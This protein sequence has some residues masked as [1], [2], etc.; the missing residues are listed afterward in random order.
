MKTKTFSL[1]LVIVCVVVVCSSHAAA[2]NLSLDPF[3]T[4]SADGIIS[5][6]A[7]QS[8]RKILIGGNFSTVSGVTRNKIARLNSDG[9]L[10][11]N[12][13]AG[14]V[15]TT[16]HSVNSIKILAD[17]KI[18]LGGYFGDV[19]LN[20]FK[21][22]VRLNPNGSLDAAF[23]SFPYTVGGG[24]VAAVESLPNGKILMCGD[25]VSA[26]GSNQQ[27]LARYNA[28][29]SL[30]AA[31][32]ATL[33]GNCKDLKSLPDGRILAGGIFSIVNGFS[34]SGLVRLNQD[35]TLDTGFRVNSVNGSTVYIYKTAVQPDGKIVA[36]VTIGTNPKLV[37]LN[38][39]GSPQATFPVVISGIGISTIALQGDG[40]VLIGGS[41]FYDANGN[42]TYFT[43]LNAEGNYDLTQAP[44]AFSDAVN[45]IVVQADGKV[46]VGGNFQTVNGVSRPRIAR[47]LPD[48]VTQKTAFDFDGDRKADIAVFRPSNGTWYFDRSSAG[49]TAT[50]FGISTDK[51]VAADYDG[52]RR[53]DIAVYRNGV[54]YYLRSSD[55]VFVY[56]FFGADGDIP[57]VGDFDGDGKADFAVFR[58]SQRVWM[59]Q[60]STQGLVT[61]QIGSELPTDRP[62]PGD[63]D[64]DGITDIAVY[65]NGLWISK[66]T[67]NNAVVSTAFG[68]A[69]DRPVVGDFDGD[70]KTD[71]AVFRPSDGYWYFQNSTQGFT[72]V[73][74][75]I[76][77][78][79]PVPADYD[80][81]GKTD[82]AV[83]RSG[84]WYQ[85]RSN[86][87]NFYGEQFG[88][89]TDVPIPAQSAF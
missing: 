75:G 10:D 11:A 1:V 15:V 33:N 4:P 71:L 18:L 78:D 64:G 72:A 45:S 89:S 6:V 9:G 77:T 27:Y 7:A 59:I 58:P 49:F 28:D 20:G 12:F 30:D 25:F 44:I 52:D 57:T 63:Y 60:R 43:R 16:A 39:D 8:D 41:N 84:I 53:T 37:R 55:S 38:S 36:F 69:E 22:V 61:L 5:V 29:G 68:A 87:N 32:P 83:N 24:T 34:E 79:L 81:D 70:G 2:Q 66:S 47:L 21:R 54:W 46:L 19:G 17:G 13:D 26:N 23:T 35:G 86:G 56:Q 51:L 14:A 80:G 85:L 88:F 3:F 73:P 40:K 31:S 65:R 50:P 74:F 76:N 67:F 42:S 62:I 82:I 48:F